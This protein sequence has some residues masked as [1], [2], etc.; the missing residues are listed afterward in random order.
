MAYI[1]RNYHEAE[2]TFSFR[3]A[4]RSKAWEPNERPLDPKPRVEHKLIEG[5]N[6]YGKY[7]DIKLY[8]TV[9]ARF[10]EPKVENGKRVERRLY[11]GHGSQT[12]QQFMRHTLYVDVGANTQ[13]DSEDRYSDESIIMPIYTKHFMVDGDNDTPFSLD[14]YWVD[15]T[16]D[17]TRSSHTPHYRMVADKD[18]RQFKAKVAAHFE[19]YIMLAQMRMPEFKAECNIDHRLGRKFGGEGFNRAYYMAMQEL[20]ESPEPRQQDIDIFFEMCQKAYDII[21]SKRGME[22]PDFRVSGTWWSRSQSPKQ[23]STVDDLAKPIEMVEFR[24][25]ILDRIHK[26][27][28]SNSLKKPEEVKQ[29][30]KSSEYPR[31]NIHT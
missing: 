21:A 17:I 27:V 2:A 4:V 29:F 28:G 7:F 31:S 6:S 13:R 1:C 20:W 5:S 25:A 9:M 3:G 16:L 18:V 19:P 14:S 23:D 26:Y 30:P 8:Q 10:Y 12:S 11:M 15:E 22:Q 24:R